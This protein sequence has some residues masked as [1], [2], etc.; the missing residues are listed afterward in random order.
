MLVI[1][2]PITAFSVVVYLISFKKH[3]NVTMTSAIKG[4]LDQEYMPTRKDWIWLIIRL[5]VSV[6]FGML[7]L[8]LA[9]AISCHYLLLAAAYFKQD[10]SKIDKL[11][12]FALL[13]KT[14]PYIIPIVL[15]LVNILAG[16]DLLLLGFITIPIAILIHIHWGKNYAKI[17]LKKVFSKYEWNFFIKIPTSLQYT[18]CSVL[19]LFL[20]IPLIGLFFGGAAFITEGYLLLVQGFDPTWMLAINLPLILSM[21][22]IFYKIS[23]L[24]RTQRKHEPDIGEQGHESLNNKKIAKIHKKVNEFTIIAV[25]SLIIYLAIAISAFSMILAIF[26][27][28]HLKKSNKTLKNLRIYQLTAILIL[29]AG[30]VGGLLAYPNQFNN[31]SIP[32]ALGSGILFGLFQWM[33][34]NVKSLNPINRKNVQKWRKVTTVLQASILVYA[35][36]FP[37]FFFFF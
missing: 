9:V 20:A 22:L 7:H 37:L 29:I 18:I 17:S 15:L 14:L 19:I 36:G 25:S 30:F 33:R 8:V 10:A 13:S 23:V 24:S 28:E 32:I 5:G 21:R 27:L 4:E 26:S 1:N 12:K 35:I 34:H 2:L 3:Y 31:I 6:L 16:G 11:A